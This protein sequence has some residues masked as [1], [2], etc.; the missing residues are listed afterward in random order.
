MLPLDCPSPLNREDTRW[1]DETLRGKERSLWQSRQ[2]YQARLYRSMVLVVGCED[3]ALDVVQ[4]AFVQA[5]LKL[6]TLRRPC[7]FYIRCFQTSY[8]MDIQWDAKRFP[9]QRGEAAIRS[10]KPARNTASRG[11]SPA[12]ETASSTYSLGRGQS[13]PLIPRWIGG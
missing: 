8:N 4:N 12:R 7:N 11:R 9:S 1:I 5:L 2:Q 6:G 3:N 10:R 13:S